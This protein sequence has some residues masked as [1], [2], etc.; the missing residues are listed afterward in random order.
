MNTSINRRTFLATTAATTAFS[1]VPRAVLGGAGYV[2]PNDRLTLA[3]IG[4]GT[5]SFSELG[6]LLEEPK[7]QI[8]SVC[9]PNRRSFN[10]VEWSK[11]S[12]RNRIRSYLGDSNWGE[13]KGCPGGR[14]IGQE[15]VNTYY[16]KHRS[17]P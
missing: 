12:I 3:H 16:A 17:G 15:V 1:V 4:M 7:I 2:A 11:N 10:Y 5:Q 9:D 13:G 6:G 8:V 14:E